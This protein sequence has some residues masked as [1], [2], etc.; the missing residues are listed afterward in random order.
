MAFR[1]PNLARLGKEI[2]QS[3]SRPFRIVVP[4]NNRLQIRYNTT[5][6]QTSL[7]T[8]SP[9][10]QA[11]SSKSP[12]TPISSKNS[13]TSSS[14]TKPKTKSDTKYTVPHLPRPLGITIPPVPSPKNYVWESPKLYDAD[15]R[16][17]E[18]KAL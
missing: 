5:T 16:S 11:S 13:T 10:N 7:P 6:P 4:V 9:S 15:R 17:A 2:S 12:T 8:S 14:I 1:P 3:P 18:R